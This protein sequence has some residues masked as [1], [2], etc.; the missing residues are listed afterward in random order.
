MHSFQAKKGAQ[1]NRKWDDIHLENTS[2][3]LPT[4]GPK[5]GQNVMEIK[6]KQLKRRLCTAIKNQEETLQ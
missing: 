1:E 3:Q 5:L 4:R 2:K 6:L